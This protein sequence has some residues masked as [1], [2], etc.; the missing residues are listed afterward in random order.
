MAAKKDTPAKRARSRFDPAIFRPPPQVKGDRK[1]S[2]RNLSLRARGRTFPIGE[3]IE[4]DTPWSMGMDQTATVT[5]PVRVLD[6][7]L[8]TLL[9]D[10]SNL[11]QD[12]VRCLIDGVI[13]VVQGVDHD[14]E[15]LYTLTLNDEVSWRLQQFSKFKASSRAKVTRFGFIQSMVDEAQ[16]APLTRMRSF[17]PEVDDKQTIRKAPKK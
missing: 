5:L 10:E 16:R 8:V 14:G 17:I 13:Y 6:D 1:S 7:S 2:I 15:G 12:G 9:G 11:Q 3:N 4:G